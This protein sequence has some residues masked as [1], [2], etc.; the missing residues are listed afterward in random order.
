MSL[1][2][3]HTTAA[4]QAQQDILELRHW[5][6]GCL[7]RVNCPRH[8]SLP[9]GTLNTYLSIQERTALHDKIFLLPIETQIEICGRMSPATFLSLVRSVPKVHQ[10]WT[11]HSTQISRLLISESL[12]LEHQILNPHHCHWISCAQGFIWDNHIT[13]T[14]HYLMMLVCVK[15]TSLKAAEYLI[16]N[17]GIFPSKT[18]GFYQ[19]ISMLTLFF[20]TTPPCRDRVQEPWNYLSSLRPQD[21]LCIDLFFHRLGSAILQDFPI[22]WPA[23]IPQRLIDEFVDSNVDHIVAK[24]LAIAYV[25][26]GL[27]RLRAQI[28]AAQTPN[29]RR[30]FGPDWFWNTIKHCAPVHHLHFDKRTYVVEWTGT[31]N[32][33]SLLV[34]KV[35]DAFV[36]LPD[37]M[38]AMSAVNTSRIPR[39]DWRSFARVMAG[40]QSFRC[41][42]D[43]F[44]DCFDWPQGLGMKQIFD[45][46]EARY[47]RREAQRRSR[48]ARERRDALRE[49]RRELRER[50]MSVA[51]SV[52]SPRTV[53]LLRQFF[54]ENE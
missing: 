41:A 17:F 3:G 8:G 24:R 34:G 53:G 10:L 19:A 32:Q 37:I 26:N 38:H 6:L 14:E 11:V 44:L 25:Q 35:D 9:Q 4:V 47:E 48:E 16:R 49:A 7:N 21:R 12:S 20:T 33:G 2:P 52:L 31:R 40:H 29:A 15:E 54:E 18:D 22:P 42:R 50:Q 36:W 1:N 27:R 13:S 46:E 43:Q 51:R 23:T 30:A 5:C 28:F 39:L 45:R